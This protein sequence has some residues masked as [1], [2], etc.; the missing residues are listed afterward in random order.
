MSPIRR[1]LLAAAGGIASLE[2]AGTSSSTFAQTSPDID[3]EVAR[4]IQL[5]DESNKALMRGDINRYRELVPYTDDFTLMSPFGGEPTHASA[6]TSER[7]EAMGRFFRNG[8]FEMEVVQAY[9]SADMVALAII[10]RCNV[11]VGG[12]P[13][14][15]WPLRV[16]LVYRRAGSEWHLAH[17]HADP[18]V[19]GISHEQAAAL[20]RGTA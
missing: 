1:S 20:A 18:L 17:R 14:Q 16:T 8:T 4:L 15:A 19:A 13:A 2:L 7:W 9:G 10:E 5:S 11:E 3:K 6:L 12:L